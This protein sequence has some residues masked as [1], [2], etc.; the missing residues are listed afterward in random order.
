M[1]GSQRASPL[2]AGWAAGVSH[3]KVTRP[4]EDRDI[5]NRCKERP[6]QMSLK[7]LLCGR[8]S[9]QALLTSDSNLVALL[10]FV[11]EGRNV[12]GLTEV[13]VGKYIES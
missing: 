9:L 10:G 12:S 11:G 6:Q 8:W 4:W 2:G 5:R 1:E 13:A 7:S 3:L